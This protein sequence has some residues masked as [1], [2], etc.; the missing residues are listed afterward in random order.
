MSIYCTECKQGKN[1]K[2]FYKRFTKDNKSDVKYQ[3][4][5]IA[6]VSTNKFGICKDCLIKEVINNYKLNK[7]DYYKTLEDICK[8]Y[9]LPF[10]ESI[11]WKF[12]KNESMENIKQMF[13]NYI[14]DVMYL[15]STEEEKSDI[16]FI[17]DDIKELKVKISNALQKDDINAHGKWMNSL[18]DAL[19]LRDKLQ[20]NIENIINIGTI[21]VQN[22]ED[23]SKLTEE[24]SKLAKRDVNL[25]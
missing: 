9:N 25:K 18:R 12:H 7:G 10:I 21:I 8:K 17:N 15:E 2:D 20:G 19:E 16:D 13:D 1:E 24:L 11:V 14:K 5:V 23:A 3:E 6:T 22:D 4:K